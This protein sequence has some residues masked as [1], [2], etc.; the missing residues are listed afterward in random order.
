MSCGSAHEEVSKPG[1]RRAISEE[2]GDLVEPVRWPGRRPAEG[3]IAEGSSASPSRHPP[4]LVPRM[5]RTRSQT[6][7]PRPSELRTRGFPPGSTGDTNGARRVGHPSPNRTTHPGISSRVVRRVGHRPSRRGLARPCGAPFPDNLHSLGSPL[8]RP[9]T[10]MAVD[11]SVRR[12]AGAPG[13]VSA[14]GQKRRN[15]SP[16]SSLSFRVLSAVS[17]SLVPTIYRIRSICTY[18]V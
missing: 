14:P 6:A 8:R 9:A 4:H 17:G 10:Q 2:K 1:H 15:R 18:S 7:V 5:R 12:Q 13:S 3:E 16:G 11:G